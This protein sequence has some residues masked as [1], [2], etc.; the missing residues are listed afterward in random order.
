MCFSSL[1]LSRRPK[2]LKK[3]PQTLKNPLTPI[4]SGR[5]LRIYIYIYISLINRS[6]RAQ[7][8]LLIVPCLIWLQTFTTHRVCGQSIVS[9]HRCSLGDF[10]TSLLSQHSSRLHITYPRLALE[11]CVL[12]KHS[13]FVIA[14]LVFTF[15]V[16]NLICTFIMAAFRGRLI[17]S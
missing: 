16:V 10:V 2:I 8:Q 3:R 9:P 4:G 14:F 15:I 6:E 5:D 7:M 1:V 12:E 17:G 11:Y 13:A